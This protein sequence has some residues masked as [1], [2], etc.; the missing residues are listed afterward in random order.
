MPQRGA[1]ADPVFFAQNTNECGPAALAMM[2]G[3]AGLTIGPDE[4]VSEVY[5]PGREGSL[6]SA[7]VAAARRHG[8]IAYPI[9]D[10]SA[11]FSEI[12]QGRQVLVLQ[13]LGL[14]W[15]PQWH[16]AVA[17][18][19]DLAARTI[20]L[21]SGTTKFLATPLS[22]FE[23]TWT[24]GEHWA[25]LTLRPGEFPENVNE[26][27]YMTS[28]A[29][30]ERA[31]ALGAA[32]D[33]YAAAL[34]RWPQNPIALMGLGNTQYG[35][36]NLR[37]AAEAFRVATTRLPDNADAFNNLGHVLAEL[38]ELIEAEKAA[39]TAVEL[40]GQNAKTY[41]DTLQGIQERLSLRQKPA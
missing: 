38:G 39:R 35:L 24:R 22:T 8:R 30:V 2:L 5:A 28:V 26:T 13:N 17:V 36:G 23:R 34:A 4:L 6:A 41:Q 1:V 16:Y 32:A 10:L 18:G 29:G 12:N 31:G 20:I 19:Y 37:A 40:G 14:S 15:F 21:H 11:V 3:H 7:M 33:A 25:L 9:N 27:T